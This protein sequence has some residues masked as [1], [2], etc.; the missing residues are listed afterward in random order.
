M[1]L[2]MV[3]TGYVG[4]VTGSCFANTGHD[5]TCLDVDEKKIALLKRGTCPIHEPGLAELIAA[6]PT[7]AG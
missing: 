7:A 5:V 4:L 3:G 2:T 1:K 6:T